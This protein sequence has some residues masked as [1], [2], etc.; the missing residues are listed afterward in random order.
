MYTEGSFPTSTSG[1]EEGQ[2][3]QLQ[4]VPDIQKE[5]EAVYYEFCDQEAQEDKQLST[6]EVAR[7]HNSA[8]ECIRE[9]VGTFTESMKGVANILRVREN[10]HTI[11][12]HCVQVCNFSLQTMV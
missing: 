9:R 8:S 1:Q 3:K 2:G 4:V 11:F 7:L 5:T 6:K 10:A 12:F